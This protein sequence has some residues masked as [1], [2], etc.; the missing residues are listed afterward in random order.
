MSAGQ[1]LIIRFATIDDAETVHRAM[2]GIATAMG[3]PE[4]VTSTPDD[5]RRF[6]FGDAPAFEALIAEA[7]GACVGVCVFFASFST[8]RGE[9]GVYVQDLFV[10]PALR[11]SGVGARLLQRLAAVTRRRGGRY[12][13]LSVDVAN[14]QAQAFYTKLGLAHS[15]AE[16]IHAAYDEDFNRLADAGRD[17]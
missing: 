7:D 12:I 14:V 4:K 17:G 1:K 2:I 16:Q 8:Y 10:E 6:G 11:G 3:E 15:A 9:P 5:I 13:R